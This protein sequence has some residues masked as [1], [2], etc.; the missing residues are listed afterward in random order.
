MV[1]QLIGLSLVNLL[2]IMLSFHLRQI[3]CFELRCL[4]ETA[5]ELGR[6]LDH[7]LSSAQQRSPSQ[8]NVRCNLIHCHR[9][10]QS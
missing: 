4:G 3:L 8:A 7:G 2:N 9:Q 5:I 1:Q 10:S 6:I